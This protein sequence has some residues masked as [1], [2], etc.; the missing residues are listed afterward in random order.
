MASVTWS[1]HIHWKIVNVSARVFGLLCLSAAGIASIDAIIQILDPTA[2][3]SEIR[4]RTFSGS[5]GWDLFVLSA[6]TGVVGVAFVLSH[7]YRPDLNEH[8]GNPTR[9]T[10]SWWTGDP[11]P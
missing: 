1:E 3:G 7:P 2:F 11:K 9:Q 5:I 4:W 8:D 10:R 6:V